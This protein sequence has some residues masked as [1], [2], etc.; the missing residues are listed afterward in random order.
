MRI[1]VLALVACWAWSAQAQVLCKM[2]N[3]IWI[4]QRL[5][6]SCPVGALEAK[7]GE[8]KPLPLRES[9]NPTSS[10]SKPSQAP[11]H[12]G[13]TPLGS[14]KQLMPF[15]ACVR[16]MTQTVLKVGGQD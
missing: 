3:G 11:E 14:K 4:E 9:Q 1:L 7:T 15:D 6:D 8:G 10:V 2:P 12:Q 13:E 16:L 5:S